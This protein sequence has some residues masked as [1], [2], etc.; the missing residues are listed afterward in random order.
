[1]N[2]DGYT[3]K[4]VLILGASPKNMPAPTIMGVINSLKNF[5]IPIILIT[6]N[7]NEPAKY[8][9]Y[10]KYVISPDPSEF[11]E[12]YIKLLK[13][14]GKFYKNFILIPISDDAANIVSNNKHTLE[15]YFIVPVPDKKTIDICLDKKKTYK[16]AIE[17]N[18]PIP[19]TY[20]AENLTDL[21][22]IINSINLPCIIKPSSNNDRIFFPKKVIEIKSV[23][24]L[25]IVC[26]K[27]FSKGCSP[28]IQEKIIGSPINLYSIGTVFNH[29]HK[30]L[31]IFCGRKIRQIPYD[32]GVGV[33]CESNW[34]P[35]VVKLGTKILKAINYYGIAH[36]EFKY[37]CRDNSY[38]LIE[39]NPRPWFW[40][41]LATNCGVNLPYIL[42]NIN[43]LEENYCIINNTK[44]IKWMWITG[45]IGL[46]LINLMAKNKNL[47]IK[48]YLRSFIEEKIYAVYS[49]NDK[50][51]FIMEIYQS[52]INL[53]YILS[54]ARGY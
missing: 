46:L 30:P 13:K 23:N 3:K 47:S 45:D 41:S 43:S 1:M 40:I 52:F 25:I 14:L 22:M 53:R 28:I 4:G 11:P 24:K 10:I 48:N 12:K 34:N 7:K 42:Y 15:K 35:T 8:S 36:V 38:K 49:K 19:K 37:D 26:N 33:Y 17:N 18:I 5:K 20:F 39:I 54:R 29:K 51:P 21:K 31:A 16:V 44:N 32:F 50:N 9:K 27:L 2:N 6:S